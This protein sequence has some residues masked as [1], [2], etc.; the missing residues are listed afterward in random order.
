MR[1]SLL[2]DLRRSD[3]TGATLRNVKF[4]Q[5]DL[6]GAQMQGAEFHENVTFE[7]CWLMLRPDRRSTLGSAAT[8]VLLEPFLYTALP[9]ECSGVGILQCDLSGH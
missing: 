4:K 7:D 9:K 5:C 6:T 8:A 3:W 2:F 1:L